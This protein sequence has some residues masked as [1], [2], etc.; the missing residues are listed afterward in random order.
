M[1][2]MEGVEVNIDADN[3]IGCGECFKVCIYEGLEMKDDKAA[4]NQE[5]CLGCGR[6]ER[7]CPNDAITISIDDYK[8]IDRLIAR[9]ESRVDITG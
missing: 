4:I 8:Q 3:C 9:F 7:I 1:K 6:C 5:N 2:R